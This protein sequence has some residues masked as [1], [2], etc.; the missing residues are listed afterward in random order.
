MASFLLLDGNRNFRET[1][2]IALRL[3]GHEVLVASTEE[4]ARALLSRAGSVDC[5]VVDAHLPAADDLLRAAEEA[6][7]LAFATARYS[8]VLSAVAARHPNAVTLAKPFRAA[9]LV[10]RVARGASAA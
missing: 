10:A 6:G 3:D 7:T 8:E 2:A 1:L 5:C 4:E 9:E